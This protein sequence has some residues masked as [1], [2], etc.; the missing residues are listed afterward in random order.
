MEWKIRQAKQAGADVVKIAFEAEGGERCANAV[1][2]LTETA[3]KEGIAIIASPMGRN[4]AA[5]RAHALK[6]GSAFA[7]CALDGKQSAALGAPPV[8]RLREALVKQNR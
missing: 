3:G 6:A 2:A 4:A 5:A 8:A 7:Y 1:D